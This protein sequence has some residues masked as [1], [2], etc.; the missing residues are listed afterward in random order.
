M[1]SG[2]N[3]GLAYPSGNTIAFPFGNSIAYPSGNGISSPFPHLPF[4]YAFL[5]DNAG[6]CIIDNQDNYI[7]VRI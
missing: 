1:A 3:I 5:V 6:D 2:G 7:I 4:G